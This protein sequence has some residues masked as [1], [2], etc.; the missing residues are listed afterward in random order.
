MLIEMKRKAARQDP[1]AYPR[2]IDIAVA[3]A[4]SWTPVEDLFVPYQALKTTANNERGQK[5]L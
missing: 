5:K 1:D 2:T 3:I 4:E